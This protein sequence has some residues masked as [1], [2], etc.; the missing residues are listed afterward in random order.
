M[1]ALYIFQSS[2]AQY[3]Q[4]SCSH[5]SRN[6]PGGS[7]EDSGG[8]VSGERGIL[9]EEFHCVPRGRAA[10]APVDFRD[11]GGEDHLSE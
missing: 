4:I 11:S 1:Y 6:A 9:P 2:G 8:T 10:D 3:I 5:Y 7:G